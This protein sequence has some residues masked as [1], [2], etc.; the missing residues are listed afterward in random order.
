MEFL[1]VV[2]KWVSGGYVSQGAGCWHGGHGWQLSGGFGLVTG[3]G[4]GR[5]FL[6]FWG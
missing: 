3:G 4:G 1:K 5:G 2:E 6:G